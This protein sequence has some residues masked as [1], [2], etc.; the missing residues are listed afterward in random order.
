MKNYLISNNLHNNRFDI[1]YHF[2]ERMLGSVMIDNYP[3]EQPVTK[4]FPFLDGQ[5]LLTAASF[6]TGSFFGLSI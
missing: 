4:N 6:A 1:E 3:S 5:T 2:A